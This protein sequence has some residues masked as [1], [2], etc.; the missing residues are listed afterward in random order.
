VTACDASLWN[1]SPD[2]RWDVVVFSITD[3]A[4]G[5]VKA[6][7]STRWGYFDTNVCMMFAKIAKL[8]ISAVDAA[9]PWTVELSSRA[10][11]ASR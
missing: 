9:K 10:H 7:E 11:P 8:D 1:P 5:A 3:G 2:A 4:T 6:E